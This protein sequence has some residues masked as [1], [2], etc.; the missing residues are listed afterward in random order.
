MK[1]R[2]LSIR[3]KISIQVIGIIA[4]LS[5]IMI[6]ASWIQITDSMKE[7]YTDCVKVVSSLG[8]RWLDAQYPGE[9]SV[10]DGK[11]YKGNTLIN[12]NHEFA[13]SM[14]KFTGGA[15]TL[16]LGDTRVATNLKDEKSVRASG[17]K[18]ATQAMQSAT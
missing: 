2:S 10:R 11:L 8:Y 12:G 17:T 1:P 3:S 18:A 13:D 5:F 9:W 6:A 15:V 16:F 7:I 14:A 4:V